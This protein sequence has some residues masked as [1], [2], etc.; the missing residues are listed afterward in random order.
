MLLPSN[1]DYEPVILDRASE[2]V[3]IVGTIKAV[4][5]ITGR[6]GVLG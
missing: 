4:I 1:P 2:T 6:T 3:G 5:R